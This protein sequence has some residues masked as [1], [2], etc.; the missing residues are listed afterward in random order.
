MKAKEFIAH[1]AMMNTEYLSKDIAKQWV[2]MARKIKTN[3]KPIQKQCS[4]TK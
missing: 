2:K 4:N 1:L 3:T